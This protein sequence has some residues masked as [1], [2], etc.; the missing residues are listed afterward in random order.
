MPQDPLHLLCIEPRFPGRLGP[1]ADWLVTHR[2]YRCQFY[3]H[4]ADPQ[5]HWPSSV[6][7]GLDLVQFNV[8][9]VAREGAAH[10]TRHLERGL[11]YA[12]GCW[13]VMHTRRPAPIDIVL[14]RSQGL[15]STL[16]VPVYAPRVPIVNLFDYYM[17]PH[18]ND[19][20]NDDDASMPAE[21]FQW[22]RSANAME[23]LDLENRVRPWIPTRWQRDLFP[24]EYRDDFA[25]LFD[26]VNTRRFR[27]V[28]GGPR[29]VAG[30]TIPSRSRVVSFVAR[31]LDRT[32]GF[33]RFVHL[34]NRLLKD[35]PDI[36]CIAAGGSPVQRGLDVQ[37]Y[38]TDYGAHVLGQSPAFDADRFWQLGAVTPNAIQE[39]L[40]VSDLHVYPSR[41]YTVSRS[42]VE[43]MSAGCVVIAADSAPVREFISDG[44]SGLLVPERD[45]DAWER[46]AL[47]V[48][49]TPANYR[50]IGQRAAALAREQYD[51]DVTLPRLAAWFDRLAHGDQDEPCV[52][53]GSSL[54][55]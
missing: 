21:Y 43:A 55:R 32:R 17:H 38:N 3:F 31:H 34:A 25:V 8:G 12:Y 49:D 42:L 27:R 10:W 53:G 47:D 46:K 33:D 24:A 35:R 13:E 15:G 1:V 48:L 11:C 7:S 23:L 54:Q 2:G 51:C 9:G 29:V 41:E 44:E 4:A 40:A 18:A 36:V 39:L 6:G 50:A 19:L 37:F 26:G 5:T 14:G 52:L 28:S 20:A 45:G 30:R 16:F 22:R